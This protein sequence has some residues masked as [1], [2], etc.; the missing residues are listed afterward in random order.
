MLTF[1]VRAAGPLSSKF[2][3]LS[4]SPWLEGGY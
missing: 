1:I 2:G 4:V 3:H